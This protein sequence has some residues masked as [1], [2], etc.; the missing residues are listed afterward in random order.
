MAMELVR[1]KADERKILAK[2]NKVLKEFNYVMV[3]NYIPEE[4]QEK[5]CDLKG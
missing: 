3:P 4:Q 2:K 1:D 5:F